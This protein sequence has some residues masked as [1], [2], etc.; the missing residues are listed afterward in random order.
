MGCHFGVVG[1]IGT[2]V[3]KCR[4]PPPPGHDERVLNMALSPDGTTVASLAADETIRL[5]K[6]FEVDPKKKAKD[7][8]PISLHSA[9]TRSIR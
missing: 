1:L 5:W 2:T 7:K 8:T 4:P 3:L 9:F 6:S